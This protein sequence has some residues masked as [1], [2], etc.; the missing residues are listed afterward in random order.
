MNW[1]KVSA[2]M[3]EKALLVLGPLTGAQGILMP[4]EPSFVRQS[5]DDMADA[6]NA[7]D[8]GKEPSQ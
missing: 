1:I 3:R 2:S 4:E 8:E 6:L 5:L 7:G